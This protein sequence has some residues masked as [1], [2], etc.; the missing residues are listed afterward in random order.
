MKVRLHDRLEAVGA[1]AWG[2]LLASARR[3]SPFLGWA[4]HVEWVRAFAGGH[5][6]EVRSVEDGA[7]RLVAV[8]PL[9]EAEPGRLML[10]GG[11][12]V[13]DYLDLIAAV[14]REEE[15]WMALLQS[16]AAVDAVWD[17]QSVP[18]TS[19]TVTALPALA[20]AC[21]LRATVTVEERCPVLT[22]PASWDAY[23]AGLPGKQRHE[24]GRKLRRLE[25]EA[26]EARVA[27]LGG[28]EE[29]ERRLDDFLRLHR[30]SRAGKARFMDS[31]M[32]EFFRR[33]IGAL[34]AGGT[35]R[36]WFLDTVSGPAASFVA[37]EWDGTVGL[38]NSGFDPDRARLAPGVVLL[39]HLIRDAIARG[40]R[41]FDFL[42][43]EERYKYEFGPVPEDV[44]AV[45]ISR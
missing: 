39:V 40:M 12:D 3:P 7:G 6:L 28:C 29:V 15:A 17:L 43:G 1:A 14:D 20:A 26:P 16:R 22:L 44:C 10:I 38:Y 33:V 18:A 30:R 19:P 21:G 13:S 31:R 34:A 23:L 36:L 24:L 5:R 8:L 37:I 35:A 2:E 25:R 11:V 41:R 4:W 9:Y 42:R 45:R 32:E 27:S